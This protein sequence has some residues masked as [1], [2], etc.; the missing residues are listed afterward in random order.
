MY[1]HGKKTGLV[2]K[3]GVTADMGK[4]T[5]STF[6]KVTASAGKSSGINRNGDPKGC[7]PMK[8]C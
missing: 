2:G 8:G 7:K 5:P 3:H 1:N 4:K 6:S